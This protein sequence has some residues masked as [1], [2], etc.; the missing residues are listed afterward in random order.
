M[1]RSPTT[2]RLLLLSSSRDGHG[3]YLTHSEMVIREHVG[4]ARR[5][6]FVPYAGVTI[7]SD[8]YTA[9]ASAPF[10]ALGDQLDS[11]ADAADPVA[12]VAGAEG[13]LVGGGNTF[14]LLA[15]LYD[16]NLIDAIRGRVLSGTPYMGWSAGAV[17]TA[18][19]IGTTNDMPIVEPR[20]LRALNLVPFQINA[21]FTDH[22]PPG[23]NGETRAE[24]LEEFVAANPGVRVL[25][26]R[27]GQ[28]LRIL[29]D[30]I[31][32]IGDGTAPLFVSGAA[33]TELT[34]NDD[35]TFLLR[36]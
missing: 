18:P 10:A 16:R 34:A 22:H 5:L 7:T 36:S 4:A 28:S 20:S 30:E 6:L 26:L 11:I 15:T 19:T 3:V 21:H 1:T 35:L 29:G 24:R 27:E 23:H 31:S 12:A 8:A 33:R 14:R 32:F 2:R 13:I 17:I 25:G 9:R